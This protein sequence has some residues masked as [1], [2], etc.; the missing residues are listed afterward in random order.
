MLGL[1]PKIDWPRS[2]V[3]DAVGPRGLAHVVAVALGE[4][5]PGLG[6]VAAVAAVVVVAQVHA[7]KAERGLGLRVAITALS[8][9]VD[10]L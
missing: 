6:R 1:T 4:D 10:L 7:L 8:Q 3:P 5:E 9:S 2:E